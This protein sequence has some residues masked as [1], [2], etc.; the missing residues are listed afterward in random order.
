[1]NKRRVKDLKTGKVYGS[2]AETVRE[3]ETCRSAVVKSLEKGGRWGYA[4]EDL[5]R[6]DC[7]Y[8]EKSKC[9][10]LDALYCKNEGTDCWRYTK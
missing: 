4:D 1:M 10:A 5:R 9:K 8:Y 7:A 2:I 3:A 6:R